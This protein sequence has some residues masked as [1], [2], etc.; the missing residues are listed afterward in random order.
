MVR[1]LFIAVFILSSTSLSFAASPANKKPADGLYREYYD[2]GVVQREENYKNYVLDGP[3]KT[4]YEDGGLASSATYFAGKRQGYGQTFY[5]NGKVQT[6]VNFLNDEID[7]PFKE[8]YETGELKRE[9]AYKAGRLQ[10]STKL[11]FQ[12]GALQKQMVYTGG[13]LNGG[14]SEFN[15]EG[16][17]VA[18]E[19]YKDGNRTS[20]K[21][22]EQPLVTSEEKKK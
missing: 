4:F 20:R 18:Q 5:K 13:T 8:Y 6:E 3:A 7:G 17:L 2:T 9:S 16:Q 10:G 15:E 14:A 21:E 12:S 1:F 22:F 11:Y 19:E